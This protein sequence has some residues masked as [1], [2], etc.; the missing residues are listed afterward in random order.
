M[1][2]ETQTSKAS[3]MCEINGEICLISVISLPVNPRKMQS[4]MREETMVAAY[5]KNKI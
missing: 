3:L 2:T 5:T 4:E 1:P